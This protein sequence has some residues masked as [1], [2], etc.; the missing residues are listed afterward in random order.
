[1]ETYTKQSSNTDFVEKMSWSLSFELEMNKL[2]V[3]IKCV[4]L[5]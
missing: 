5:Q 2:N 1:M 3:A 4:S